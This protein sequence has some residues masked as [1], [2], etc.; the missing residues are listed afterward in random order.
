MKPTTNGDY[1]TLEPTVRALSQLSPSGQKAVAALVRQLAERE[2]ISVELTCAPALK[3]PAELLRS[4]KGS[5]WKKLS[6]D[7]IWIPLNFHDDIL[8]Y[9]FKRPSYLE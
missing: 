3:L 5:T 2:G 4:R 8:F 9:F 1:N 6:P 7:L